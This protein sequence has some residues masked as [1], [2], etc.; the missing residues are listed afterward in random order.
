MRNPL[1]PLLALS[2]GTLSLWG[3]GSAGG[4]SDNDYQAGGER[5]AVVSVT[6]VAGDTFVI[7]V[8]KKTNDFGDD[9]TENTADRGEN[10]GLPDP[11]ETVL[12]D[13][14]DFFATLSLENKAR[15]QDGQST[16]LIVKTVDVTYV[17]SNN[18]SRFKLNRQLPSGTVLI[19]AG[20]TAD[21]TIN[22]LPLN[23]IAQ[24]KP[25]GPEAIFLSGNEN[26]NCGDQAC[27]KDIRNMTAVLDIYAEDEMNSNNEVHVQ[28]RLSIAL[29]NPMEHR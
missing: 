12:Q 7:D 26:Q 19:P 11:N 14:T 24:E 6:P 20:S 10:D 3:C 21:L 29:Q 28:T 27:I 4:G 8:V 16:D 23:I 22:L 17:D 1:L 15:L 25:L 5:L 2:L 18:H 9:N 13:V